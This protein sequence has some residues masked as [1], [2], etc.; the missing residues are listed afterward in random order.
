[1]NYFRLVYLKIAKTSPLTIQTTIISCRVHAG[2]VQ[3]IVVT[4][5]SG[6]ISYNV[7]LLS[8]VIYSNTS[9]RITNALEKAQKS[10]HLNW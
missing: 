4:K 6:L 7:Q 9:C 2:T 10:G 8:K 1:M 3:T 5:H